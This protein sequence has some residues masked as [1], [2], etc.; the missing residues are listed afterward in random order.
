[1]RRRVLDAVAA[2]PAPQRE[3]T[4]L[5]YIDGYS[6]RQVAEFLELPV[7]TVNNRLR[8]AR[9]QLKERMA[10]MV[11][12]E[13]K[14]HGLDARFPRRIRTLLALPRPLEIPDHPVRQV[15][16]ALRAAL[17]DFQRVELDELCPRTISPICRDAVPG[18]VLQVDAE[19]ILRHD[20][21]CGLID[22][23]LA[24]GGGPCRRIAV[25]RVFREGAAPDSPT[26][27]GTFHNAELLWVAEGLD[28]AEAV[29]AMR[30][31]SAAVLGDVE[32]RI[33]PLHA[34]G[35]GTLQA[36]ECA[37]RWRGKWLEYGVCGVHV[38]D[39]VRR[40]GLDPQRFAAICLAFGLERCVQIRMNL[41][42]IHALWQPPY[43]PAD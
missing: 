37:A 4:T 21:T 20:L 11:A 34:Q 10:D 33:G 1:M 27:L 28:D 25:G 39:C 5:F 23:W 38:P 8:A 7:T 14:A 29:R 35:G 17:A 30:R 26:H 24:A 13:L 6:Q 2:L 19:R 36:R 22:D 15:W 41:P 3:A 31:T 32:I 40:G 16:E 43:V 18:I 42:D 9:E 12:D